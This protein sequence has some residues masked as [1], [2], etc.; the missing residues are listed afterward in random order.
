MGGCCWGCDKCIE[1]TLLKTGERFG[2]PSKLCDACSK[3]EAAFL[4]VPKAVGCAGC[5]PHGPL[6]PEGCHRYIA[7]EDSTRGEHLGFCTI[8][9][10][11]CKTCEKVYWRKDS[12]LATCCTGRRALVSRCGPCVEARK[13]CR[14]YPFRLLGRGSVGQREVA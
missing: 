5:G 11:T 6:N 9:C 7:V 2:E 8:W 13:G 1:K 14:P 12:K 10:R 3:T 4:M